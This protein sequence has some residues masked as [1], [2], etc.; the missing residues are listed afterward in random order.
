MHNGALLS[1]QSTMEKVL[2]DIFIQ[3][4]QK[5]RASK[6]SCIYANTAVQINL[7]LIHESD[8]ESSGM[9]MH[10]LRRT[11]CIDR[12]S[13]VGRV[14]GTW[15]IWVEM[16]KNVVAFDVSTYFGWLD[17]S[18]FIEQ[19]GYMLYGYGATR[20]HTH[21]SNE[22]CVGCTESCCGIGGYTE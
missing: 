16:L 7:S 13:T 17:R 4:A 10:E 21:R 3:D 9:V 5:R 1:A 12:C 20:M 14:E 19:H 8:Q 22:T 18:R 11:W 2:S 15:N 6:H